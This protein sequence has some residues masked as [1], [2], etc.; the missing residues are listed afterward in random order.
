M[1]DTAD[2]EFKHSMPLE[3]PSSNTCFP[4]VPMAHFSVD[5]SLT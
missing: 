5:F 3:Q 2:R 1:L 4:H